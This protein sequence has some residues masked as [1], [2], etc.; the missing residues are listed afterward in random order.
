MTDSGSDL[1][2]SERPHLASVTAAGAPPLRFGDD[3]YVWASWLYY[4]E[5]M[6]QN[7]IAQA[8]G[9]SRAT[10]ISYLNEA[11]ERGI[12]NISIEPGR[13]ASLT[14]MLRLREPAIA[15]PLTGFGDE[16]PRRHMAIDIGMIQRVELNP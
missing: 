12:V 10:V 1:R 7:D 15:L 9:I 6:T 14:L 8:M 2:S 3:Q 11:R 13:L 16:R 5:G 4:Q